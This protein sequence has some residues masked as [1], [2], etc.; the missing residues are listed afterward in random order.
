MQCIARRGG[1]AWLTFMFLLLFM[2]ACGGPGSVVSR[3]SA[4]TPRPT[5][6][7]T[8]LR[9]GACVHL[10]PHPQPPF[11]NVR[12][13][14]DSYLAHS[15]P[16]LAENPRN[17]LNLVGGSKFFTDPRH[18]R[19][20]I[21]FY[22]S[23]DGGC[24][25]QDGGILPGFSTQETTS[26]I[27]FAFGLH[28]DFYA[29]VLNTA[30]VA[31][32]AESG[33]SVLVSRDGGRTFGQPVLVFDDLSGR[34]FS[35]KPWLAV[36]TTGGP[37]S[38]NIYVVWSYDHGGFCGDGN[39]CRQDLAFARSS[40]GGKH[41]TPA[42]FVEGHAS[43]C[44]NP[45]TGRSPHDTTC[46]GVLGATPTV[47]PDGTLAVAFQY[48]D[49]MSGDIPTRLAVVTSPDGGATWT[50]P[51]LIAT[52]HDVAGYFPPDRYRNDSLPAFA[53]DPRTG[54]LYI[55]WSDKGPVDADILFSTSTD[56]GRTW[57][58]FPI[59]VNDDP[60][61]DGANQ[62]QPQLA[63]APDGVVSISFFDTRQDLHHRLIDVYLAQSIDYGNSFLPN[64]RVTT[65]SWNPTVGAPVDEFGSLFIGDYQGLT[66]DNAFVHPFWNDTRT[67][68][69]EIFTA[70]IPGA[71]P[72]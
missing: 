38:G 68:R 63:V 26:D 33:V 30:S 48:M 40:D 8:L 53:C 29:L 45:T 25:W 43:F 57:T 3:P 24:T 49:V 14:Q 31:N 51:V 61:D 54:Q 69:Q 21:G 42:R 4:P 37:H 1:P 35:D 66:A 10:G 47:L 5:P 13:S 60:S 56:H 15:E 17:P 6:A 36:D 59:R 67:G 55:A 28:N 18:Y 23:F 34:T 62:F 71:Q 32:A 72:G 2:V 7:Y 46:D 44:T 41:F 58:P 50:S 70:A 22:S 52:I 65:Q 64:V 27:T 20:Q 11:A 39:F 16:M 12:V 19:F 9:G